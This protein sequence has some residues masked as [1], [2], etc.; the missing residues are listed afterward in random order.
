[1]HFGP[2][3]SLFD[4]PRV[5][6]VENFAPK[7]PYW[8]KCSWPENSKAPLK[9]PKQHRTIYLDGQCTEEKLSTTENSISTLKDINRFCCQNQFHSSPS[10]RNF[11]Q[12][13]PKSILPEK[14]LI[15]N[16]F[17]WSKFF[18]IKMMMTINCD[19]GSECAVVAGWWDS[20]GSG[21]RVWFKKGCPSWPLFWCTV[22]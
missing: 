9:W 20:G 19:H 11:P 2:F 14:F 15:W 8:E 7:R 12:I 1:M 21:R 4:T 16:Y 22:I 18:M 3:L 10:S 6:Y 17:L 5:P 13:S